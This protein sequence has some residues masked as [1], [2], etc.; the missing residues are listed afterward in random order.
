MLIDYHNRAI[1]DIRDIRE[2]ISYDSPS[3]AV[4]FINKLLDYI[5]Y[6]SLFPELGRLVLSK[7]H[8]RKLVYQNYIILYQI[9]Y[10]SNQIQILT[11]FHSKKDINLILKNIQQFL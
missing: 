9:N 6:L 2:Y 1:K 10:L 8:I 4:K 5:S 11:I 7:Y 3:I